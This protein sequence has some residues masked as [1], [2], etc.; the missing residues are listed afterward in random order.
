VSTLTLVETLEGLADGS[1]TSEDL[2]LAFLAQ[3]TK[4][5]AKYNA[6]T[7]MN[8]NALAQ[9]RQSDRARAA[10]KPLGSMAGVRTL[11]C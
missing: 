6:F 5:E 9:A 4:Y 11:A 7:A 3:I 10:S 2:V 1:F 8:E